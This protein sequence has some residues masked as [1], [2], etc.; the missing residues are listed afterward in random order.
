[1]CPLQK[2]LLKRL[3]SKN[4]PDWLFW[5]CL[6]LLNFLLF[7]PI[8]LF[9]AERASFWP[10]GN[11]TAVSVADWLQTLFVQ[12]SNPDIFRLHLEWLGLVTLWVLLRPLRRR[13][14][15]LLIFLV[16][17]GQLLYATYE[18][19]IRS[20]YLLDP[21]FYNDYFLFWDMT[22][23][24][25]RGLHLPLWVYAAGAVALGG[26]LLA[27]WRLLR[28]LLLGLPTERLSVWTRAGL[29]VL[30]LGAL[31]ETAVFPTDIGQPE[32]A[33][34]SLVMK[35]LENSGRSRLAYARVNQFNSDNL[36]PHYQFTHNNLTQKPD[37]Y[38][39]FVESYGSVLYQRD[40]LL[41]ATLRLHNELMDK[42]RDNGWNVAST[43]SEAPTWGGASWV[44]YTSAL[45]GLRLESHAQFLALL[46]KYQERPFPHLINYLHDQGYRTYRLSSIGTELD[47]TTLAA[48]QQFYRFD[49]WLQFSDL[50]YNGPLYGW[51]PSPP[52]Q[53][54]LNAAETQMEAAGDE[55]HLL[56]FL[57]QNSHY[58][59]NPLPT[60][61]DDWRTLPDLPQPPV[62]PAERPS[63]DVL[64]QHYMT[65]VDYDLKTLVD[66]IVEQGDD[67]DLFILI[68]D[69]QPARVARYSDGWDTPVHII[70]RNADL[71]D[72]FRP[73]ADF[74]HSL[75][76]RDITATLHHEGLYSLLMRVLLTQYGSDPTN[77]PDYAPG[78]FVD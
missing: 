72:A 24:V 67:N 41:P 78:G 26:L 33:V 29:C 53:Y 3:F 64:R 46:D 21:T 49:Q 70:S 75:S 15:L 73:Y 71:V 54:A 45:T 11:G 39:L 50:D 77:V 2:P 5:G 38:L 59:W 13:R 66:F 20:F 9:Q 74:S 16:L 36:A 63:Y 8:Y 31:G 6:L 25:L 60:L 30:L 57:T 62:P 19:F 10:V 1:M 23:N 18:G 65:A 69:H 42:L 27:L 40:D 51:G 32:T 37:I 43:R 28:F 52:D 58:P 7:L 48:Y 55:P 17:V 12:R 35:L 61:A 76:T 44:S 34:S 68:G 4:H 14:V 47:E 22:G 56:F